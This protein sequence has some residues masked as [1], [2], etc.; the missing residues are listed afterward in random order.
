MNIDNVRKFYAGKSTSMRMVSSN[1]FSFGKGFG[2]FI[3]DR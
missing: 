1:E 2:A 3:L